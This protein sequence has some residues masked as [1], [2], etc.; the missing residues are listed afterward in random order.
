MLREE[1]CIYFQIIERHTCRR[2]FPCFSLVVSSKR[3]D[4]AQPYVFVQ[5]ELV[6][7]IVWLYY[8]KVVSMDVSQPKLDQGQPQM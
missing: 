3:I 4:F 2:S 8:V 1:L 5:V 7:Q 6:R